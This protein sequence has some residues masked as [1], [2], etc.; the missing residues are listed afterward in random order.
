MIKVTWDEKTCIHSANCVKNLPKVFK[1]VSNKFVI[2]EG[3]ASEE[4]IR[5]AVA[6]CPSGALKVV[7][8]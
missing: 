7:Q 8:K 4:A 5:A 6:K 2:D 3:G 1:V